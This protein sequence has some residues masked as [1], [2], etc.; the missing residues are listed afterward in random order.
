[1][2]PTGQFRVAGNKATATLSIGGSAEIDIDA[3]GAATSGTITQTVTSTE[4]QT[5]IVTITDLYGNTITT[6]FELPET[7]LL[8]DFDSNGKS[9]GIGQEAAS[10]DVPDNGRLDISM[11]AN[12]HAPVTMDSTLTV[13][14]AITAAGG[15]DNLT[16]TESEIDDIW[17]AL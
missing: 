1:M 15:I 5:V 4:A 2:A 11:D 16:I 7:Y 13:G 12:L 14:G 8:L 3:T 10:S 6:S 9:I 17:N